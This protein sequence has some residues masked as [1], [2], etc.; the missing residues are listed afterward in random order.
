MDDTI[1]YFKHAISIPDSK[2][3]WFHGYNEKPG[4]Q[5]FSNHIL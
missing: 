1:K 5:F 3:F 2:E 4:G